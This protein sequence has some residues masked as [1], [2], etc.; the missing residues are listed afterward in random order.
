[1][2][3]SVAEWQA[4]VRKWCRELAPDLT[5]EPEAARAL[6]RLY[7]RVQA[8]TQAQQRRADLRLQLAELAAEQ[9]ACQTR[10][11]EVETVLLE[12]RRRAA[13]ADD[14][15]FAGAAATARRAHELD[16]QIEHLRRALVEARGAQPASEFAAAL[17]HAEHALIAASLT[18]LRS[19]LERVEAE[20]RAANQSVGAAQAD[21][22]R[23][24]GSAAAAELA[25]GIESRRAELRGHVAEYAVLTLTRALLERQAQRYQERHQPQLLAQVSGL[26]AQLT[27]G[28]Y[29]RVYQRL[30]EQGTFVAV[31]ADGVEVTPEAMSTGTREQLYLAIR[32][33]YV[34]AYC[35]AAEPLPV[36]LDDVLVNFDAARARATL[37]VLLDLAQVTQVLFFTCHPH[38]VELARQLHPTLAMVDLAAARGLEHRVDLAAD[39]HR[40]PG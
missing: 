24:D 37:A 10:C 35:G 22:E 21:L 18:D 33:A 8:A 19:E 32:V 12:W 4:R 6:R 14:A 7:E 30:D 11:A 28:S 2:Q 26:F 15:A 34:R 3:S 23:L 5:A 9:C 39:D 40:Q 36:V 31:R 1:L 16:Q 17:E 27:M 25:L 29:R 20:Y 38:L 13:V